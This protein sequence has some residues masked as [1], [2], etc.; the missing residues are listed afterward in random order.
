MRLV[1]KSAV[2]LGVGVALPTPF[3]PSENFPPIAL[4]KVSPYPSTVSGSSKAIG[5]G[6]LPF[7][8]RRL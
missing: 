2:S 7:A 6:L 4:R 1:R 5:E 8:S 3:M